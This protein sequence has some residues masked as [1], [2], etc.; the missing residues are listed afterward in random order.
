VDA[1]GRRRDQRGEQ[2]RRDCCAQA[3]ELCMSGES[4]HATT[5]EGARNRSITDA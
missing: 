3:P 5:V 4:G 1:A 2:E